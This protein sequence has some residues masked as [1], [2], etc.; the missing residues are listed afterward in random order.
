MKKV[1]LTLTTEEVD[2]LTRAAKQYGYS[3]HHFMKFCI[4]KEVSRYLDDG[5]KEHIQRM[6][7]YKE[8]SI[9][10]AD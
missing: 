2:I 10:W 7:Q 6:E 8:Q 4:A 3:L 9:N 5:R 1:Q